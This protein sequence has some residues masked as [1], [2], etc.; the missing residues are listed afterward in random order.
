M[1]CFLPLNPYKCVWMLCVV[2]V[3]AVCVC[4]CTMGTILTGHMIA[5]CVNGWSISWF[6]N[7]GSS[8][9]CSCCCRRPELW[10]PLSRG[11][12]SRWWAV[13]LKYTNI[14]MISG[15]NR[16]YTLFSISCFDSS[17]FLFP[18]Y[19]QEFSVL[20]VCVTTPGQKKQTCWGQEELS[21]LSLWVKQEVR[22]ASVEHAEN[23]HSIAMN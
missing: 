20:C 3:C 14:Q 13:D 22:K 17:C 16:S 15:K 18:S 10:P 7:T 4:V 2:C 12:N 6:W 8:E 11:E 1:F 19:F 5:T 23:W 9:C 21:F